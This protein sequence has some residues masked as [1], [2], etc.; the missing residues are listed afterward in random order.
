VQ[1][2]GKP[3]GSGFRVVLYPRKPEEPRP[4][5][6]SV[7]NGKLIRVT[8]PDQTHWILLSKD[9][10]AAADGPVSFSGTAA[11]VKR[12]A[13]G[14]AHLTLLEAGSVSH[15]GLTL[16]GEHSATVTAER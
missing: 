13:N 6:E 4:E 5:V 16:S 10:A 8:L 1:V 3:D 9:R 15:A 14:R 7:A 12:W 11:V 2:F